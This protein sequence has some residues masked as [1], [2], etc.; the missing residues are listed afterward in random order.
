MVS[1]VNWS[2]SQITVFS[3]FNAIY[4]RKKVMLLLAVRIGHLKKAISWRF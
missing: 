4:A 1:E 2:K 3:I